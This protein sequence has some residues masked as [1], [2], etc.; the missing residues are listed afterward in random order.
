MTATLGLWLR[1]MAA[2]TVGELVGRRDHRPARW[3]QEK[4]AAGARL[5]DFRPAAGILVVRY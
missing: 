4:L 5:E 1:W 2:N 3:L